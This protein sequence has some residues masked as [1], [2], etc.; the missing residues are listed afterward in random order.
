MS[1][2]TG[3]GHP[4]VDEES[5]DFL[6]RGLHQPH[7]GGD[8]SA[9]AEEPG[10]VVLL[11]DPSGVQFVVLDRG[12]EVPEEGFFVPGDQCVADHFVAECTTDPGLGGVAD[13]V[14]VEQQ[15]RAAFAGRQRGLGA[16]DAVT[17]E[18]VE[19]DAGLVV[20]PHVPWGGKQG[21]GKVVF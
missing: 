13:V 3:L 8:S 16:V 7:G 1:M 14:E 9:E 5:F 19:V 18:S 20:D 12:S 10:A 4:G 15:E 11:R 2:P 21:P 17:A 6:N